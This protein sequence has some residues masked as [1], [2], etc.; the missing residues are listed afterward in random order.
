MPVSKGRAVPCA[1]KLCQEGLWESEPNA[2]FSDNRVREKGIE[3]ERQ[4]KESKVESAADPDEE[5]AT[6][7]P[8][9]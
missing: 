3:K 2:F 8:L 4:K 5:E 6:I 1:L 9:A 7:W